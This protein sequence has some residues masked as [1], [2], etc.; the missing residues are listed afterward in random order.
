VTDDILELG[1]GRIEARWRR[2]LAK[3]MII[4]GETVITGAFN[5]TKGR[6]RKTPRIC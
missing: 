1:F 4:D 2:S 3:V 6:R 5:F